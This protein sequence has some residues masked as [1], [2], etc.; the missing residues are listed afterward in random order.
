MIALD[1]STW[2]DVLSGVIKPPDPD[3]PVL[4][5]PHFDAEVLGALRALNQRR[6]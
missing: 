1:A 6:I 4:V 2:V 5:P 3:E